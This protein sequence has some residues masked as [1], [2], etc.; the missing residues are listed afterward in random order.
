VYLFVSQLATATSLFTSTM[1]AYPIKTVGVIGTGVIG[2]SWTLFFLSKGLRVIATDPAPGAEERLAS[3]LE[4]GW[5]TMQQAGLEE[6]ASVCNYQFVD[7]IFNFLDEID[8]V[9]EVR[10]LVSILRFFLGVSN[11]FSY[12]SDINRPVQSAWISNASF[13][14]SL[15]KKH[16][17]MSFFS[18]HHLE[19]PLLNL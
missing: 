7:N 9:Q 11:S 6:G 5:P 15:M 3:Y 2:A 13:L 10:F 8:L 18:L 17:N 12:L 4:R 14:R 16:R 1:A 19:F